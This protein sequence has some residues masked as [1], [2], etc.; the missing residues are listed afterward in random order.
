[1]KQKVFSLIGIIQGILILILSIYGDR[2]PM[3][4]TSR[5]KLGNPSTIP[6]LTLL[7]PRV[8]PII[9]GFSQN[10][11]LKFGIRFLPQMGYP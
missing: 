7:L 9:T 10:I 11:I 3:I 8:K 1:M 2:T 6:L 4:E 5:W